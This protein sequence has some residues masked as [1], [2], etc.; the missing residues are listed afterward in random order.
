MFRSIATYSIGAMT[1]AGIFAGLTLFLTSA[2]PEAKA[3]FQVGLSQMSN[4]KGDRLST[5]SEGPPCSSQGWPYYERACQFDLRQPASAA[6]SVR[7]VA[8]R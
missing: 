1:I 5:L 2:A 4:P 3:D 7:V 8:F 6:R